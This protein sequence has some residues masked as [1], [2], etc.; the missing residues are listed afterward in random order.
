[1]TLATFRCHTYD[2]EHSVPPQGVSSGDRALLEIVVAVCKGN[3]LQLLGH[4]RVNVPHGALQHMSRAKTC[5]RR[6]L[7]CHAQQ[8]MRILV[9]GSTR[10]SGGEP[11]LEAGVMTPEAPCFP[12]TPTVATARCVKTACCSEAACSSQLPY[13][14]MQITVTAHAASSSPT[15]SE[16]EQQWRVLRFNN[17]RQSVSRVLLSP[18]WLV[19]H[20]D[21]TCLA[22]EYLKTM[23]SAGQA[24]A[25]YA[26][27]ATYGVAQAW[28]IPCSCCG[29]T[30]ET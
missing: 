3:P 7:R 27:S 13:V 15:S 28:I 5:K 8:M 20:A 10:L 21:A 14:V 16:L 25:N 19:P 18:E 11:R 22:F 17:T 12:S 2:Y 29:Q 30:A 9:I 23:A 1:M 4:L 26:S 24:A 6:L